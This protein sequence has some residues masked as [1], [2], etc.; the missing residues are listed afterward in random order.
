[1]TEFTKQYGYLRTDGQVEWPDDEGDLATDAL[2]WAPAEG[3]EGE[4]NLPAFHKYA[5]DHR[6]PQF[7]AV[8]VRTITYG[9]H[10]IVQP[11]RVLPTSEKGTVVRLRRFKD[12]GEATVWVANGKGYWH[13]TAGDIIGKS[14]EDL[15]AG[16]EEYELLTVLEKVTL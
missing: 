16:V 7:E 11:P 2:T 14:T 3:E 8:V 13:M 1:M 15:F 5:Q 10:E 6:F 9:P 4:Q 12:E